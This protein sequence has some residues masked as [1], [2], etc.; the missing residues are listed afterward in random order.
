MP[1]VTRGC[2]GESF[3]AGFGEEEE[4]VEASF[5]YR[6]EAVQESLGTEGALGGGALEVN[7]STT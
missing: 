3:I 4:E 6:L 1:E 5:A 7:L 2:K